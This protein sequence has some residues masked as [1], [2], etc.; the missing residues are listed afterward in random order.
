MGF[1]AYYIMIIS[2]WLCIFITKLP[3]NKSWCGLWVDS[4]LSVSQDFCQY[5]WYDIFYTPPIWWRYTRR[6]MFY[7]FS[8]F[9]MYNKIYNDIHILYCISSGWALLIWSHQKWIFFDKCLQHIV[10]HGVFTVL[11]LSLIV[12]KLCCS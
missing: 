7:D 4:P 3:L 12:V 10:S 1:K 5:L 11:D 2:P 9:S 6:R 8:F